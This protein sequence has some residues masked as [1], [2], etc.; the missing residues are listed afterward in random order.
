MESVAAERLNKIGKNPCMVSR[1]QSLNDYDYAED[2]D[3][4]LQIIAHN[5]HLDVQR[6][7]LTGLPRPKSESCF[8]KCEYQLG[9]PTSL[10]RSE[11]F[12]EPATSRYQTTFFWNVKCNFLS[13][14]FET[15]FVTLKVL[16]A[17]TYVHILKFEEFTQVF[18]TL[19]CNKLRD[20][21]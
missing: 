17:S 12:H 21:I 18:Y 11:T 7:P 8:Q 1:R 3:G 2:E 13:G 9:A 10:H 20:E 19:K 16:I 14:T 6:N 15:Y 5:N 4:A